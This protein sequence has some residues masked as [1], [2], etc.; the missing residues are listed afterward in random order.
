MQAT[1]INKNVARNY[2]Y[3][4]DYDRRY[5]EAHRIQETPQHFVIYAVDDH[6]RFHFVDGIS[7]V[8]FENRDEAVELVVHDWDTN[9]KILGIY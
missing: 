3:W 6:G 8:T 7:D 1:L 2:E 4:A 9:Y 5:R